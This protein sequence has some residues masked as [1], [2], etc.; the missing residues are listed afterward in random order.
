MRS[1]TPWAL[2]G[3]MI[4]E[5]IITLRQDTLFLQ[6]ATLAF[7]SRL[8]SC[9]HGNEVRW[10]FHMLLE[11]P[12]MNDKSW[13]CFRRSYCPLTPP[14]TD[15]TCAVDWMLRVCRE[16]PLTLLRR[17]AKFMLGWWPV[18]R[19]HVQLFSPHIIC[20][21]LFYVSM[22]TSLPMMEPLTTRL[23]EKI[24]RGFL[25]KN[26]PSIMFPLRPNRS[27]DWTELYMHGCPWGIIMP[28]GIYEMLSARGKPVATGTRYQQKNS[29]R[30]TCIC[31]SPGESVLT[32]KRYRMSIIYHY[33]STPRW[34]QPGRRHTKYIA[35]HKT[36]MIKAAHSMLT[37][38]VVNKTERSYIARLWTSRHMRWHCSVN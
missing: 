12:V 14:V 15:L 6:N 23:P 16:G 34:P 7:L 38:H 4:T 27:M 9:I 17:S 24:R 2:T 1:T 21:Y 10:S 37:F 13:I 31:V 18:K 8:M 30:V 22:C 3:Y 25:L 33:L 36:A 28:R 19:L 29:W 11:L 35:V 32:P 5:Y 20:V 26:R